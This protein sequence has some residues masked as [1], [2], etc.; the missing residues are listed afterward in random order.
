MS[1]T[2]LVQAIHFSQNMECFTNLCVILVQGPCQ[3]S[4]YRSNFSVCTAE[5][6]TCVCV[7]GWV[8]VR[9]RWPTHWPVNMKNS[10]GD[11]DRPLTSIHDIC[12]EKYNWKRE[13]FVRFFVEWSVVKYQL[14]KPAQSEWSD[15]IYFEN[16]AN[17][18]WSE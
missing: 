11:W 13:K 2:F 12:F 4:M 17:I 8:C 7:C 5:A 14:C 6:S 9:F 1:N 3:S 16:G 10:S 18:F 15:E